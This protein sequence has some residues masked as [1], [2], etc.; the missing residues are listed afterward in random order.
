MAYSIMTRL[1]FLIWHMDT[2]PPQ[3]HKMHEIAA[4][5]YDQESW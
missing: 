5:A 2:T 3:K 4:K 1:E